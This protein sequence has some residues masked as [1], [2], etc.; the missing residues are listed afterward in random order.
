MAFDKRTGERR[1][2]SENRDP[3]G[4][5]G[6]LSPLVVEN[7]PCLAVMTHEGLVVTRIDKA[8]AGK[9]IAFV[10]WKTEF[11]NSIASPAV[12]E[13]CVVIT[14]DY[15]HG[16]IAKYEISLS[17]AREVW[18]VDHSSSVCTPVI[19]KGCVYWC[20]QKVHCL[21]LATG[22][23][24]WALPLATGQ[25]APPV[26]ADGKIYVG[27]EGGE[28]FIVRPGADRGEIVSKV[29]LPNST[30]SCCGSEGTAEQILGGVA[31]S[32]GRIYFVSSDA[33]YASLCVSDGW[34]IAR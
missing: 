4:H 29:E 23:A 20:W 34:S 25:K 12:H 16:K 22:K 18:K 19:H 28:F 33:V 26:L 14:S 10:P 11:A 31:I 32:R 15:N 21:D 30:N 5:A 17:G 6:C 2:A 13:N 1:W 7:V 3:A 24:L 27:T 8:Q 9:Q